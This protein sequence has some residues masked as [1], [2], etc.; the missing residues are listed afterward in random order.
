MQTQASSS[1]HNEEARGDNPLPSLQPDNNPSNPHQLSDNEDTQISLQMQSEGDIS[2]EGD[3]HLNQAEEGPVFIPPTPVR[4]QSENPDPEGEDVA[5]DYPSRRD[6]TTTTTTTTTTNRRATRRPIRSRGTLKSLGKCISNSI[7]CNR[8]RLRVN[9]PYPHKTKELRLE[10]FKNWPCSDIITPDE[11]A[12]AG[13][14]YTGMYDHARCF[15]CTGT[16]GNWESGDNAWAAHAIYFPKCPFLYLH[17]GKLFVESIA[18]TT[19]KVP[20]LS[21]AEK[22]YSSP[23]TNRYTCKICYENEITVTFT[24]CDH[25]VCCSTCTAKLPTAKCPICATM[26]T[27]FCRM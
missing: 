20:P 1:P 19:E 16:I 8:R 14:F 3:Q 25:A 4:L 26:I 11:L 12:D 5:N 27:H 6:T 23:N 2:D 10:T 24:P 7:Y 15:Q 18:S 9:F 22:P 17:R 13:F 21:E